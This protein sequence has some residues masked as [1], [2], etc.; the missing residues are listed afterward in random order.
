MEHPPSSQVVLEILRLGVEAKKSGPHQPTW[1]EYVTA[2]GVSGPTPTSSPV[3]DA[4]L[5]RPIN[6]LIS[7]C[8]ARNRSATAPRAR[9]QLSCATRPSAGAILTRGERPRSGRQPAAKSFRQLDGRRAVSRLATHGGLWST[10]SRR[11]VGRSYSTT[12]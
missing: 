9:R 12:G 2:N 6:P 11:P 5:R 1:C 3:G 4:T 10:G 8:I 7:V